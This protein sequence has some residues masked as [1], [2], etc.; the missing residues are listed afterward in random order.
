MIGLV[1]IARKFLSI[2]LKGVFWYEAGRN[3]TKADVDFSKNLD[4][5]VSS[6]TNKIFSIK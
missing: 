5:V 3:A 1:R 6:K 4:F 2:N